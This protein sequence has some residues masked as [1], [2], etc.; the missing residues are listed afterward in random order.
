MR[1]DIDAARLTLDDDTS[2]PWLVIPPAV[3]D[4][5]DRVM[6]AGLP[7]ADSQLG[8]PSLGVKCGCNEAFIV[9]LEGGEGELARVRSG[10]RVGEVERV[11]L[12]PLLRGE[13][14]A[15][16]H[17]SD[18]T[19]RL[20]W[21]HGSGGAPL[22]RLPPHADSWLRRWRRRLASRADARATTRWWA[23][24]RTGS[25][26]AEVSRLV[27]ADFGR[28]PRALVL[29]AGDPTVALNSCYVLPCPDPRDAHAL[30]ALLNSALA[31]AWLNVL[32]EPAR[33]GYRRYLAWTVALLPIP[34]DWADARTVLAPLAERAIGGEHV[35]DAELL[36]AACRAYRVRVDDMAP[37]LAWS[38]R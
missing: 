16:W 8:A 1:W 28:A 4:A 32:A 34:R 6:R 25:A 29:C 18:I 31:A 7:L 17:V 23:L 26:S 10:R 14:V 19:E 22:D 27:W 37:L 33:G 12:R 21:T 35:T 36:A 11:L 38:A 20:L 30:A 5:F 2:S 24:F 15:P 13:R 3:R 9:T